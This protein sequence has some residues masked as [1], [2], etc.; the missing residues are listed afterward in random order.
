[1]GLLKCSQWYCCPIALRLSAPPRDSTS[2][3]ASPATTNWRA[4]S[5]QVLRL[6]LAVV[7]TRRDEP[8]MWDAF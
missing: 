8:A 3:L 5:R 7:E 1:M 2:D 4:R 6:G